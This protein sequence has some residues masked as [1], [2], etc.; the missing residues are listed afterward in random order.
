MTS[1]LLEKTVTDVKVND[2]AVTCVH[3]WIIDPP[4]GPVSTG[5]CQKCGEKRQFQ[6]YFPH[7][8]WD[9][10]QTDEEKAKIRLEEWGI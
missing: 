5:M 6:N 1:R 9:V 10:G 2:T 7:S 8:I 4:D 3:H